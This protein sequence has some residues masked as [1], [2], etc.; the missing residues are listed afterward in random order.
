MFALYKIEWTEYELGWGNRSDG[1]TFYKTKE[2]AEKAIKEYWDNMPK[3]VPDCYSSP[4]DPKLVEVP[5]EIYKKYA[6]SSFNLT[7]RRSVSQV[8]QTLYGRPEA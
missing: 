2:L 1:E 5:E 8:K 6:N 4:S 3:E 7:Q